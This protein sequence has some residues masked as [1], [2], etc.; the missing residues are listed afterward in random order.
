MA[1][2]AEAHAEEDKKRKEAIEAR[3][4]LDSAIYQ[5]QKLKNDNGDKISD[6]DKKTLDEAVEA[7]QKVVKDD[8]ASKEDLEKAAKELNDKLMPIG[9][10]MYAREAGSDSDQQAQKEETS[11]EDGESTA[12]RTDKKSDDKDGPVEGEVVDEEK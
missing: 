12:K 5:A 10:K 9:A 8:K 6:D 3:N 7:A 4:L 11:S 2:D 1:K